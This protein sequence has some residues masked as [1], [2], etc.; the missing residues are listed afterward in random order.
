MIFQIGAEFPTHPHHSPTT[1]PGKIKDTTSYSILIFAVIVGMTNVTTL[2]FVGSV[3]ANVRLPRNSTEFR[4]FN[5]GESN[6]PMDPAGKVVLMFR[7]GT[8]IK[9]G[10]TWD[11]VPSAS[12]GPCPQRR[13]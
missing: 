2:L 7:S 12:V 6:S 11:L 8:P 9:L 13:N 1:A 4:C 5:L 10:A 3:V